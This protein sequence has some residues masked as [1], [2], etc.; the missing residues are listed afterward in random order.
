MAEYGMPVIAG[1]TTMK[2]P[3]MPK[4]TWISRETT[5]ST[6]VSFRVGCRKRKYGGEYLAR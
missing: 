6:G 1:T 5:L 3:T 4:I 2:P